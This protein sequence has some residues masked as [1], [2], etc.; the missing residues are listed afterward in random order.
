MNR[1]DRYFPDESGGLFACRMLMNM[2]ILV[3]FPVAC[4]LYM[5]KPPVALLFSGMEMLLVVIIMEVIQRC[6]KGFAIYT[7]AHLL[8]LLLIYAGAPFYA[9]LHL[10]AVAAATLVMYYDRTMRR[11]DFYPSPGWLIYPVLIYT[12]GYIGKHGTLRVLGVFAEIVLIALFFFYQNQKGM[13][14]T[15][16]TAKNY[17]RVPYRKMKMVNAWVFGAFAVLAVGLALLLSQLFN[18]EAIV[19]MIGKGLLAGYALFALGLFWLLGHLFPKGGGDAMASMDSADIAAMLAA[20]QEE[21]PYLTM[22]W[23]AVQMTM[24]VISMF[25]AAYLLYRLWVEFYRNFRTADLE[26]DDVRLKIVNEEDKSRSRAPRKTT[27]RMGFFS[28]AAKV[29]RMYVRYIRR[30]SGLERIRPSHTPTELEFAVTAR[31]DV[32]I[33]DLYERARY[34]PELV[35][36]EHVRE[37]RECCR[38]LEK[39]E[40]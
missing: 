35:T 21:H 25:V 1:K 7:L 24:C 37:M 16:N 3:T 6:L 38:G 12:V 20:F 31:G 22:L 5:K 17:V 10:G 29:R 11:R 19:R 18:G 28:P 34:A 40:K 2:L 26:T 36:E 4:G 30:H 13:D 15:F 39:E 9:Y 32:R 8:V 33:R 23:H 27:R 14:R